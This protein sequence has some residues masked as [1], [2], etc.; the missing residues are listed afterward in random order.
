MQDPAYTIYSV[1][2]AIHFANKDQIK[3]SIY[4]DTGLDPKEL[5]KQS[6]SLN[7]KMKVG[8]FRVIHLLMLRAA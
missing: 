2:G 8:V 4:K 3:Q 6:S 7:Y 1:T 5:N